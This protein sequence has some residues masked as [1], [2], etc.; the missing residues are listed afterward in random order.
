MKAVEKWIEASVCSYAREGK[1]WV[2]EWDKCDWRRKRSK[3]I[4]WENRKDWLVENVENTV[5]G[6]EGRKELC[7]VVETAK[8]QKPPC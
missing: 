5:I 1:K 3:V 2:Q 7:N 8:M 4:G 6:W